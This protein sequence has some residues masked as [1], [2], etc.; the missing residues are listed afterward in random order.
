MER[1]ELRQRQMG[2]IKDAMH[3]MCPE[4]A[5]E[6]LDKEQSESTERAF[7]TSLGAEKPSISS[8]FGGGA[9]PRQKSSNKFLAK[10]KGKGAGKGRSISEPPSQTGPAAVPAE[11]EAKIDR[12]DKTLQKIEEMLKKME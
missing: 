9:S 2:E 1:Q 3:R 4:H 12:I 6:I 8:L 5:Q 7:Q 11:L 10:L